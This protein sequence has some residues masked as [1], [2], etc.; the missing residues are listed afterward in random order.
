VPREDARGRITSHRARSTI[1]SQ[2][3]N[4]KEPMTL[5]ELQAWLGHRSPQSTQHYTQ[6]TPT[7]L[8]QAYADAGYF[9]RN[10]RTVEVLIDRE[11][12]QNGGA[13]SGTPWQYFDLGHGYCTYNFFEQCPHRMACARCDFYLPKASSGAPLLEANASL[14]RMMLTIPLTGDERAAVEEG[15]DAVQRLLAR[16]ADTP[17]PAGPTPRQTQAPAGPLLSIKPLRQL[18]GG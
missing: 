1:A 6:I 11:T 14:Q 4:A 12:V 8:A 16:L 7:R 9:G 10:V 15:A 18:E 3:Y 2:L 13:A 17:T 5:F